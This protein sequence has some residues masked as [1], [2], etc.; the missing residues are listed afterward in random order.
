MMC[1]TFKSAMGL[2]YTMLSDGKVYDIIFLVFIGCHAVK[3][4]AN[5]WELSMLEDQEVR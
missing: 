5:I 3:W 2:F 4:I 1:P